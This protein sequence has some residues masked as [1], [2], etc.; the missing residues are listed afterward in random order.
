MNIGSLSSVASNVIMKQ[1]PSPPPPSSGGA[2]NQFA[3]P[4][5]A[6]GSQSSSLRLLDLLS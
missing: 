5:A 3:K 2:P 4:Q 1:N 6:S